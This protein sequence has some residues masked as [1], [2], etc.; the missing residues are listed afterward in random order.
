MGSFLGETGASEEGGGGVVCGEA[1][2]FV[3]CEGSEG[4]SNWILEDE[5]GWL[6]TY[7]DELPE[8]IWNLGLLPSHREEA[9]NWHRTHADDDLVAD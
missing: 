1:S 5:K 2:D 9:R 8:G 7:I 3:G 4:F 6:G